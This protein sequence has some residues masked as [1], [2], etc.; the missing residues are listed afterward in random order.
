MKYFGSKNKIRLERQEYPNK[1]VLAA[2]EEKLGGNIL[3]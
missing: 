1:T 3:G 2:I